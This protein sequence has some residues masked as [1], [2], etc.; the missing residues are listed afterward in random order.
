[1][2]QEQVNPQ[3]H[4]EELN[5]P[6]INV[7]SIQHDV[8]VPNTLEIS[9]SDTVVSIND[10]KAVLYENLSLVNSSASDVHTPSCTIIGE[11]EWTKNLTHFKNFHP[12]VMNHR[13]TSVT[14]SSQSSTL[15]DSSLW[16]TIYDSSSLSST[17]SLEEGSCNEIYVTRIDAPI[18]DELSPVEIDASNVDELYR[19]DNMSHVSKIDAS[20]VNKLSPVEIDVPNIDELSQF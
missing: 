14:S 3:P 9:N 5:D 8:R 17:S 11:V 10:I 13:D 4:V 19:S 6:P 15:D 2:D 12:P 7:V 16:S 20:I 18:V 1:M